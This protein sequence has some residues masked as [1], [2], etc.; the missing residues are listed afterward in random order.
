M[1]WKGYRSVWKTIPFL[2]RD[3]RRHCVLCFTVASFTRVAIQFCDFFHFASKPS[4]S[5]ARPL[6]EQESSSCFVYLSTSYRFA[7]NWKCRVKTLLS[8]QSCFMIKYTKMSQNNGYVLILSVKG[9]SERIQRYAILGVYKNAQLPKGTKTTLP[10]LDLNL[11]EK[12]RLRA[13][14]MSDL[15]VDFDS[16]S[17]QINVFSGKILI[18]VFINV[19]GFSL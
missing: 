4:F 8:F 17:H 13:R 5:H 11:D 6:K 15:P 1:F 9:I 14:F 18:F 3:G 10:I 2:L 12:W 7:L 16:P 19:C